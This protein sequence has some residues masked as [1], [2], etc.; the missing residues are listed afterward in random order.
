MNC[1]HHHRILA[2]EPRSFR[3]LPLPLAV[4]RGGHR[5]HFTRDQGA[6][7]VSLRKAS[8]DHKAGDPKLPWS[9]G[10]IDRP[11]LWQHRV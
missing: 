10:K 11:R 9:E 5:G 8:Y 2:V 7:I 6:K 3:D 4:M 1:P